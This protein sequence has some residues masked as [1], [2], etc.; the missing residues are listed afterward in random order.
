MYVKTMAVHRRGTRK[1]RAFSGLLAALLVI[2]LTTSAAGTVGQSITLEDALA[3]AL[4]ENPEFAAA[5]WNTGIA[6]GARTQAGLIPNPELS[7]SVED[8]RS[9]SRVTSVMLSQP[10]ELGGKRGAE[11]MLL[12]AIRILLLLILNARKTPCARRSFRFFTR[13]CA[14]RKD[15]NFPLSHWNLPVAAFRLQQDV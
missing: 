8:T 11:S 7:W 9:D 3:Q 6:G 10:I 15:G 14:L 5:Q 13:H 1:P 4:T 2:P 12:S